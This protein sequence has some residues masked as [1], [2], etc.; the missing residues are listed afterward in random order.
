MLGK[1]HREIAREIDLGKLIG[2]LKFETW[3]IAQESREIARERTWESAS[4]LFVFGD[5]WLPLAT[6]DLVGDNR[7]FEV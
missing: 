4:G 2:K 3:E 7:E 6:I 1:V 5:H